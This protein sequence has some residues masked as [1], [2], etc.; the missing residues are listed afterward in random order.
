[1]NLQDFLQQLGPA[2]E[3]AIKQAAFVKEKPISIAAPTVATAPAPLPPAPLPP[4]ADGYE[5]IALNAGEEIFL[6]EAPH[7]P[8]DWQDPDRIER[9]ASK[10][11][12]AECAAE[13]SAQ[14]IV[15]K[16]A[17]RM[18]TIAGYTAPEAGYIA[19]LIRTGE[20]RAILEEKYVARKTDRLAVLLAAA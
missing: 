2:P 5:R 3:I 7:D 4:V 14:S 11:Q 1:M 17:Y 9:W 19:K 20:W 18:A 6:I 13:L 16:Q 10:R 8:D 12:Q 15:G